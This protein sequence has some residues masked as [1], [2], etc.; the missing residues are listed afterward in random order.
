MRLCGPIFTGLPAYQSFG[1]SRVSSSRAI[2]PN[3]KI[4]PTFWELINTAKSV[5][6]A[7]KTAAGSGP[8]VVPFGRTGGVSS[9]IEL[10]DQLKPLEHQALIDQLDH[11]GL[12]GDQSRQTAGGDHPRVVAQFLLDAR[13]HPLDLGREAEDDPGLHALG[14]GAPDHG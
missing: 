12:R 2:T 3:I 11:R 10:I 9:G 13:H 5:A 6:A 14:G 8:L 4:G 7:M 1:R